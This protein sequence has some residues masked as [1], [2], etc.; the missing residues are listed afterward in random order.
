MI[1]EGKPAR[2][3]AAVLVATLFLNGC[4]SMQLVPPAAGAALPA[5]V[6]VGE[7]IRV[8]D[9]SGAS[10]DM[11][12]TAIGTDYVEGRTRDDRAMRIAFTDVREVR[13]RRPAPGRTVLLTL[14]VVY[15]ALVTAI[16]ITY[17]PVF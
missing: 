15:L 11:K 12:V 6:G 8:L 10:I 13:E 5:D 14:G 2:L 1:I 3:G 9:R 16:A 4:T 17:V 7:R